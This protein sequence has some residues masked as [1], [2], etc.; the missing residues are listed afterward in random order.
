MG[1]FSNGTEGEI[2]QERFCFNC[3]N[4]QDKDDGRG[5]GCAIWDVHLLN[6]YGQFK[7]DE[8]KQAMAVLIPRAEGGENGQCRQFIENGA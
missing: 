3:V 8:L 2:Y 7:N 6:N 1:Y 4:W 5:P